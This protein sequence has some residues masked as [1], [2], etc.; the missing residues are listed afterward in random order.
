MSKIGTFDDIKNKYDVY[1]GED[2]FVSPEERNNEE[3]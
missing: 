3:N 1:R 2:S